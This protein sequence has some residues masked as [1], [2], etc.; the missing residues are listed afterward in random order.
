MDYIQKVPKLRIMSPLLTCLK[1][2]ERDWYPS[3]A[4]SIGPVLAWFW[5]SCFHK[6]DSQERQK[7]WIMPPCKHSL[8]C[9]NYASAEPILP[10][11][12]GPVHAQFWHIHIMFTKIRFTITYLMT[13]LVIMISFDND[14]FDNYLHIQLMIRTTICLNTLPTWDCFRVILIFHYLPWKCIKS[15]WLHVNDVILVPVSR[16]VLLGIWHAF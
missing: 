15:H 6:D 11:S 8:M 3:D 2:P 16:I 9:Q 12:I 4:S 7:S 5:H 14:I 10:G 13:Y 1:M